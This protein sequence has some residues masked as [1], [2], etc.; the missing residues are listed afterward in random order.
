VRETLQREDQMQAFRDALEV[1]PDTDEDEDGP[2]WMVAMQKVQRAGTAA[3]FSI[4]EIDAMIH[5]DGHGD[6]T[7][8]AEHPLVLP[9]PNVAAYARS[10]RQSSSGEQIEHRQHRRA[11]RTEEAV[12]LEQ[13]LYALLT[14]HPALHISSGVDQARQRLAIGVIFA[15][16][17]RLLVPGGRGAVMR[18]HLPHEAAF[19]EKILAMLP[20]AAEL[21]RR[22]AGRR[23]RAIL[24]AGVAGVTA[25]MTM[26]AYSE[27]LTL[28]ACQ[29]S[30]LAHSR[31][32]EWRPCEFATSVCLLFPLHLG[33][34]AVQCAAAMP[35]QTASPCSTRCCPPAPTRTPAR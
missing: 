29:T 11:D 28:V 22:A 23:L 33:F 3:G 32:E 8:N 16:H 12:G 1:G 17:Q 26:G 27:P 5:V 7:L 15:G 24:A 25:S 20:P 31:D 14:F 35:P 4:A 30:N 13:E 10:V 34:L 2:D 6:G 19:R 18:A 9:M 21:M